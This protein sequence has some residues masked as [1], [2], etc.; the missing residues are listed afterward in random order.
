MNKDKISPPKFFTP[1][2][3]EAIK[4]AITRAE[5]LTSGEIGLYIDD[6]CEIDSLKKAAEIFQK[7][8]MHKTK[9]RGGVLIYLSFCDHKF[10]II[11][12][13]RI[14][15]KVGDEFWVEV[16]E[17]MLGFFKKNQLVEGLIAGIEKAGEALMAEFPR[18]E[19]D[20]DE[21]SNEINYKS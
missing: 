19:D 8:E 6:Y 4:A 17:I 15:E 10:A 12:D 18:Q 20:I 9:L 3:E 16:K 7:L 21:I 2:E 1:T 5:M 14:H 13:K 11:G